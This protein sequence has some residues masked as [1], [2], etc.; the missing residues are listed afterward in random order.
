MNQ[1]VPDYSVDQMTLM[2]ALPETK[3]AL[4]SAEGFEFIIDVDAAKMSTT[5]RAMLD[6]GGRVLHQTSLSA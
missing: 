1:G 3:V 5:L 6:S 4:V 2:V